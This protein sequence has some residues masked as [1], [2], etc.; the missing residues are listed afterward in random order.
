[1]LWS[2]VYLT[3]G[4]SGTGFE[5]LESLWHACTCL[6]QCL[7]PCWTLWHMLWSSW[8]NLTLLHMFGSSIKK[9]HG[10]EWTCVDVSSMNLRLVALRRRR[11]GLI[12][13]VFLGGFLGSSELLELVDLFFQSRWVSGTWDWIMIHWLG[14][15]EFGF[16]DWRFWDCS[17]NG[18]RIKMSCS[19]GESFRNCLEIDRE[20]L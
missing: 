20:W 3:P 16:W 2:C 12:N 14:T 7:S 8:I 17:F 1:M 9:R 6:N 4:R 5:A 11:P 19:L 13:F 18:I 10:P 15:L